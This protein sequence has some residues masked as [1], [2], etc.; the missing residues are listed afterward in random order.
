MGTT[1]GSDNDNPANVSKLAQRALM[2]YAE[3]AILMD[4]S[5]AI[6]RMEHGNPVPYEL[7]TGFWAG[8]I[9]MTNAAV[10]LLRKL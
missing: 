8:K 7:L 10:S 6:W 2:S 1:D 4:K 3:R 5:K 9:E